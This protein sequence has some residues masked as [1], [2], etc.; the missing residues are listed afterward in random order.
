MPTSGEAF[1][2]AGIAAAV[3]LSVM[4]PLDVVKTQLQLRGR[5]ATMSGAFRSLHAT[6]GLIGFWRGFGP[7]L[8]IVVPRRGFK[9]AANELFGRWLPGGPASKLCAGALA[10]ASEALIITPLEVLKVQMQSQSTQSHQSVHA[11][12]RALWARAGVASFYTGLGATVI[13]HSAHSMVYFGA[14]QGAQPAAR[15]AM[16]SHVRGDLVAG[17][18]AGVAA[19]T[20]NNPFDVLKTRLQAGAHR[21]LRALRQ[22]QQHAGVAKGI[23]HILRVEGMMALFYGWTAKVARLGPGS[24]L[25]FAVYH[26]ILERL[27]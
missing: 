21:E 20:V 18:V 7:G 12:A 22:Q 14:F 16:R 23:A 19:G 4:Q 8:G 25:I 6:G 5:H 26:S 1:F 24:A 10:G 9:F 15:S 11:T 13:K 3:E 2:A 27:E 17:F